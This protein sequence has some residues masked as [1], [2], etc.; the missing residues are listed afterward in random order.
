MRTLLKLMILNAAHV[1]GFVVLVGF[2]LTGSELLASSGRPILAGVGMA[3]AILAGLIFL[4]GI[5]VAAPNTIADAFEIQPD[6]TPSK[7]AS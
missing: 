2:I 1:G 5:I 6:E 3:A 4:L 7:E